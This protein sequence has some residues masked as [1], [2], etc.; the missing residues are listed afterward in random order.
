MRIW[1]LIATIALVGCETPYRACI[2]DNLPEQRDVECDDLWQTC[3]RAARQRTANLCES[4]RKPDEEV[5][6]LRGF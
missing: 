6:D 3:E 4:E 5:W 2:T 1:L